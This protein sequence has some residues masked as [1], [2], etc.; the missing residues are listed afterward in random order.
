MLLYFQNP[1]DLIPDSI[2]GMGLL[3]DAMIVSIMLRRHEHALK[4][5][6]NSYKLHWPIPSFE[7]DELLSVISPLRVSSFYCSMTPGRG[8]TPCRSRGSHSPTIHEYIY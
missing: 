5:S 7:V 2:P 8:C 4:R 1:T 3:D 6:S